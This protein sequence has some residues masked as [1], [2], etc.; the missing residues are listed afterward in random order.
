MP[1]N[2]KQYEIMHAETPVCMITDTGQCTL[3]RPD[4]MPYQL[5]LEEAVDVDTRVNNVTNFYYWCATRVL[6]LDRQYVKQIL[7]S[8]GA[9]QAMTDRDRAM[10]ALTY[11]CLSLTDVFW[12]REAGEQ[13]TYAQLNLYDNHLSNAFVDVALRGRQMTVNNAHLVADDVST[14]GQFPKAWLREE[15]GFYLLKDGGEDAVRREL[16]ASLIC[17]CFDCRQVVYEPFVWEGTQVSRSRLIADRHYGMVTREAFEL[18]AVNHDLDSEAY[19]LELD[20]Y[21]YHMM[22]VLDYLIGNTDRHWGNWGFLIDN[23]TNRPLR[24]YDLMDF[25]Q[26]FMEYD[27]LTGAGC[28]TAFHGQ[29]ITQQEAALAGGRAVGW[30]QKKEIEKGWFTG[31]EKEYEMLCQRMEFLKKN[32]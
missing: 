16:L 3:L 20:A 7:N 32:R 25:N 24:L 18:Y 11:H 28:Q 13:V 17:Q 31:H 8:I 30:N 4:F 6:T 27:T 21:S 14:Q 12:V 22:N 19:V 15:D 29:R 23:E 26:A 10:I 2:T 5:Y 1:Y 9:T